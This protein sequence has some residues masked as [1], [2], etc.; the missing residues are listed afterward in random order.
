MAK[1][2][3]RL[4]PLLTLSVVQ[5]LRYS[6][7]TFPMLPFSGYICTTSSPDSLA[8][9]RSRRTGLTEVTW[10]ASFR[11]T[12]ILQL[13]HL[14]P[15]AQASSLP[16]KPPPMI[17]MDSMLRETLSNDLKSSICGVEQF[18]FCRSSSGTSLTVS[19]KY[20]PQSRHIAHAASSKYCL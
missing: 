16:R 10:K 20:A 2:E 19:S 5:L 8:L 4:S 9:V 15:S 18:A 7:S 3:T 11:Y 12:T 13:L 6:G 17:V 1:L 14:L